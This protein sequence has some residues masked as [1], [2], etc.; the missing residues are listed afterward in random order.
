MVTPPTGRPFRRPRKDDIRFQP[1][2]YILG[3]AERYMLP[4]GRASARR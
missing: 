2:G 1:E 4:R 3:F